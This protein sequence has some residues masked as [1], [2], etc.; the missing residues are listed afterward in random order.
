MQKK[1][2]TKAKRGGD[3]TRSSSQ[4]R[5]LSTGGDVQQVKR[6]D[7]ETNDDTKNTVKEENSRNK[8]ARPGRS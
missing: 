6:G 8:P 5:K 7:P 2:N 3:T 1:G 4:G